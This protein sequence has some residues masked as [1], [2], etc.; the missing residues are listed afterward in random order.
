MLSGEP[1]IAH[2]PQEI[3]GDWISG[4]GSYD[5]IDTAF[6]AHGAFPVVNPIINL[7]RSEYVQAM[8]A[9]AKLACKYFRPMIG[10]M[11]MGLHDV[12]GQKV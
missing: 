7:I 12:V 11:L 6:R 4:G 5:G 3:A 8:E 9:T 2:A 10:G 1:V